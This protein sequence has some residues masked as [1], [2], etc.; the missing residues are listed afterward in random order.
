M[1]PGRNHEHKIVSDDVIRIAP[2][3]PKCRAGYLL[4]AMTHPRLGRP[5][6]K[7]LPYGSSIPHIEVED[8]RDFRVP[9]LHN[10]QEAEIADRVEE[11]ARLRDEANKLENQL[12]VRAEIVIAGFLSQ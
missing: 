7:T 11:A 12:G 5:R 2:K 6:I 8:V 4:M 10:R 9:R 1:I 3:Y